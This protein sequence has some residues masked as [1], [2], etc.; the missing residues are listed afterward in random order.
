VAAEREH[1][2]VGDQLSD[3]EDVLLAA[4]VAAMFHVG[5]RTVNRWA[6]EQRIGSFRTL[7]GHSPVPRFRGAPA[8][9]RLLTPGEAAELLGAER[10][11][12]MRLANAGALPVIRTLGGHRRFRA[13]DV[14]RLIGARDRGYTYRQFGRRS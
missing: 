13:A 14:E 12:V 8:A 11:K 10:H 6:D 5:R 9:S 2:S 3:D 1:L 4:E 7:G